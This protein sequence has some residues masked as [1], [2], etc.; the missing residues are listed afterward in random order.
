MINVFEPSTYLDEALAVSKA[1]YSHWIGAGPRADE[2]KAEWARHVNTDPAHL[3]AL[4]NC[5]AGLFAAVDLC[6]QPGDTVV[7]PAIHFIGAGNAVLGQGRK[8]ALCDVDPLTLNI[9]PET[10][11]NKSQVAIIL[12]HYGGIPCDMDAIKSMYM[13]IIED[14]ACAPASTYRGRACG[15]LGD[16]GLWSFDAMKVFTSG[17][18][19]M[20]W[21]NN[22]EDARLLHNITRLGLPETHGVHK[23]GAGW[24]EYRVSEYGYLSEMNDIAA[25]IGLAQLRRLP[26]LLAWRRQVCEWYDE[27]L[28]GLDWLTLRPRCPTDRTDSYYFYWVQCERRDELALYLRQNG[29]YTTFKYWPLHWAYCLDGSYL[30]AER[31]SRVT[32]LLPCHANLVE[33][34]VQ[35]VCELIREFRWTTY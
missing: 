25:A 27:G 31:A 18:G 14:A 13:I 5:T 7:V 19:G 10:I 16:V 28:A 22:A 6:T 11:P 17:D 33:S 3:V 32:L 1:L 2:F 35:K 24:W 9:D 12:D 15:T 21:L 26:Q 4:H 34:D 29:V 30:G 20:V 23:E 8:L